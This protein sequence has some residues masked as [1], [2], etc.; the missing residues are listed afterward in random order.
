MKKKTVI[1]TFIVIMFTF[2]AFAAP[3]EQAGKVSEPMV[4]AVQSQIGTVSQ[5]NQD[6]E[7]SATLMSTLSVLSVEYAGSNPHVN[8]SVEFKVQ[9]SQPMRWNYTKNIYI[10]K[11]GKRD[12]CV[13]A[14]S[15]TRLDPQDPTNRTIIFH[16]NNF[17]GDFEYMSSTGKM[18]LVPGDYI[19]RTDDYCLR[20]AAGDVVDITVPLK[21]PVDQ[22]RLSS[23][24][25]FGYPMSS[26]FSPSGYTH[27]FI[28][29]HWT[30]GIILFATPDHQDTT[31]T[32]GIGYHDLT[33]GMNTL[34]IDV[35]A[36][37]AYYGL[38]TIRHQI[39]IK[40]P[41]VLRTDFISY[42]DGWM[43][44]DVQFCEPIIPNAERS[45]VQLYT[46]ISP[47]YNTDPV[48]GT[49]CAQSANWVV[50][51]YQNTVITN[52]DSPVVRYKFY[53]GDTVT[54][55]SAYCY[56]GFSAWYGDSTQTVNG[57]RIVSGMF[58]VNINPSNSSTGS[59][60]GDPADPTVVQINART[61]EAAVVSVTADK[62]AALNAKTYSLTYDANMLQL[63]D[64]VLLTP[65]VNTT[66]GAVPNSNI[67]ITSLSPGQLTFTVNKTLL[68]GK[69]LSGILNMVKFK[70]LDNGQT[71]V[72]ITVQ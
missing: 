9:F 5:N 14:N 52:G 67:T 15:N 12:G 50:H 51:S 8:K 4:S 57:N 49:P 66:T 37:T 7:Q 60:P 24:S 18:L 20:T 68:S 72:T 55:Q 65:A 69:V 31:V 2:A 54:D 33:E 71:A 13:T 43:T 59:T 35:T 22:P 64:A 23:L 58:K 62:A 47:Y 40:V 3:E 17:W 26:T 41:E 39:N 29:P 56:I 42:A 10:E 45:R 61:N 70:C 63:A 6:T 34:Y 53:T 25:I 21:M 46:E 1:I 11:D 16:I 27:T 48:T 38:H 36:P 19:L 44:V 28:L 32:A 30:D